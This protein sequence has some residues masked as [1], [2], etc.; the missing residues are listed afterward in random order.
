MQLV[1]VMCAGMFGL[2]PLTGFLSFSL[3]IIPQTA[4]TTSQTLLDYTRNPFDIG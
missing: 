2:N 1:E 4:T 3:T